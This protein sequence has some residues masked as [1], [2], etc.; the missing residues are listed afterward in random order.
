MTTDPTPNLAAAVERTNA[1][2]SRAHHRKYGTA[3]ATP[4]PTEAEEFAREMREAED[5]LRD[6]ARNGWGF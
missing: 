6:A 1:L 2:L 3:P 4:A 5:E